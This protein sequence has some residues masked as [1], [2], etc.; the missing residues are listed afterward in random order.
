MAHVVLKELLIALIRIN[1]KRAL[2]SPLAQGLPVAG[3]VLPQTG[4]RWACILGLSTPWS[5]QWT[6]MEWLTQFS[7]GFLVVVCLCGL[8]AKSS[9]S[10]APV[11]PTAWSE[12]S[13]WTCN[14]RLWARLPKIGASSAPWNGLS[15]CVKGLSRSRL[16]GLTWLSERCVR[17]GM[18]IAHAGECSGLHP[19]PDPEFAESWEIKN[20]GSKF[21]LLRYV[22]ALWADGTSLCGISLGG[23]LPGR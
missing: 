12:G 11:S 9:L 21:M 19:Q 18:A 20:Q 10:D 4:Q 7:H 1:S 13:S 17:C 23:S 8:A 6:G 2:Y 22:L 14:F 15:L 16:D 5:R 3:P